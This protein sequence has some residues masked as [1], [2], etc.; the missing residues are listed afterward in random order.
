VLFEAKNSH[1]NLSGKVQPIVW[2]VHLYPI[3]KEMVLF[4]QDLKP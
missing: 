1:D 2:S 3:Q 4:S